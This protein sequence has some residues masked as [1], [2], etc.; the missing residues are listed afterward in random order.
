MIALR[1]RQLPGNLHLNN[2]WRRC[3][4]PASYLSSLQD[5]TPAPFMASHYAPVLTDLACQDLTSVTLYRSNENP[6]NIPSRPFVSQDASR[7][8]PLGAP[9]MREVSPA[10]H[11]ILS[12][13]LHECTRFSD[14]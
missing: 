5:A 13:A 9:T 10:T 4:H 11:S 6:S 7:A 8:I 3:R 14:H 1:R 12:M 2:V